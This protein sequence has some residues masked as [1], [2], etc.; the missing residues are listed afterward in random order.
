MKL[1]LI[2]VPNKSYLQR[3]IDYV[4]QKEGFTSYDKPTVFCTE[5]YSITYRIVFH[6]NTTKGE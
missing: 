6:T 3:E 2:Q 1:W 4:M 5:A